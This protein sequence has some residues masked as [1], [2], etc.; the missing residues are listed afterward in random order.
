MNMNESEEEA[1]N[2]EWEAILSG[3][4]Q[5]NLADVLEKGWEDLAARDFEEVA[6]FGLV[7]L[8]EGEGI[9][10][11]PFFNDI[12]MVDARNKKIE[13]KPP[14]DAGA[15]PVKAPFIS[16]F[17]AT[18]LVHYL[19]SVKDIDIANKP[20]SF[21]EIPDGGDIYFPAFQ[22]NAIRPIIER[23]GER[24]EDLL[25]AGE[26]LGSKPIDKGDAAVEIPVFPK[27]PV[28]VIVWAGDEEIPANANI[29]FDSTAKDQIHI[30][31]LAVIGG[32]VAGKL[33]KL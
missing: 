7:K 31:D 14:E 12:F 18:L 20:M 25:V 19:A 15:E 16:S 27:I 10:H 13:F 29:L 22:N 33:V 1:I 24:P 5:D 17:L 9:F 30:E 32:V 4:G 8:E 26:K 28:T 11:L 21:R 23:Y 2:K 6:R 3:K